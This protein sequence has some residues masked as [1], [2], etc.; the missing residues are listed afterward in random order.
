MLPVVIVF[1]LVNFLGVFSKL[2]TEEISRS[3]VLFVESAGRRAQKPP[4]EW[5]PQRDRQA[6][7]HP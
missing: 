7:C 2:R 6:R 1:M 3:H 5:S 4:V